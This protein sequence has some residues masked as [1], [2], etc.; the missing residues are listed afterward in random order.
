MEFSGQL[1][2]L[3]LTLYGAKQSSALFYKLLNAFLL[4]LG[5]VSSTL[6]PC[7]YKRLNALL[8]VHVDDMRCAGT[9]TA[10]TTIQ[11]ALFQ[12]FKI[13]TGD[14]FRFLGMD[15]H[16]DLSA[17]VLTMGMDTYI[18]STMDRF[19]HFDL[20]LGFPYREIVGCLL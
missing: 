19:L 6:D 3:R 1:L 10:L 13:T 16:Y 14:G 7:F 11:A 2:K 18:K 15:T 4:S 12:R 8:I 20:T 9:P 17:G 5:F